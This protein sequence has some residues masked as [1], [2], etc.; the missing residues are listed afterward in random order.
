M[1]MWHTCIAMAGIET[2][3]RRVPHVH[4][5]VC[6]SDSCATLWFWHHTGCGFWCSRVD[7]NQFPCGVVNLYEMLIPS[8]GAKNMFENQ[9][10]DTW[11]EAWMQRY[12]C[13]CKCFFG[14]QWTTCPNRK[15]TYRC[16]GSARR[17][18]CRSCIIPRNSR[19]LKWRTLR[20]RKAGHSK[21]V[22]HRWWGALHHVVGGRVLIESALSQ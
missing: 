12:R 20:S 7:R 11:H 14:M 16:F 5:A 4:S 15:T 22:H 18:V 2:K 1:K 13:T 6:E 8:K 19:S 21:S 3:Y 9:K 17:T 10:A